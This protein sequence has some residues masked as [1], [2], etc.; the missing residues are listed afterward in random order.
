[1]K[2]WIVCLLAVL[3]LALAGCKSS[4]GGPAGST[5]AEPVGSKPK[6]TLGG[7]IDIKPPIQTE[8]ELDL[9]IRNQLE[10]AFA[11]KNPK[12]EGI[13]IQRY[14]GSFGN[15]QVV[16]MTAANM[17][18]TQALWTEKV[19]GVAVHYRNGNRI[20]V[21]DGTQ[22]HTLGEAFSAGLLTHENLT[23]IAKLQ[24]GNDSNPTK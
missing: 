3:L 15:C 13:S 16:M 12:A 6:A 4:T 11:K 21:F 22:L 8:G 9:Q 24:N 20:L 7:Q 10:A 14:Y 2:K 17:S 18:Y 23:Q 5:P 1:M 19:D